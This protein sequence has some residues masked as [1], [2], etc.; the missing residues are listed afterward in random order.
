MKSGAGQY[1]TPRALINAIVDVMRPK[2]WNTVCD[3]AAGTGGFLLAAYEYM[4]EGELDPDQKKFLRDDAL[5]GWEIVDATA[6]LC[7]MN[8]IL[9]GIGHP[10]GDS[11]I[12]VDDSLRSAPSGH[13]DMVLD[14]SAIREEVIVQS[15]RRRRR[16]RDRVDDISA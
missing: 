9:H 4:K 7:A 2:A 3:P 13:F 15:H 10:E 16:H 6:R 14:E 11:L 8:L 5:R 12:T 1:F